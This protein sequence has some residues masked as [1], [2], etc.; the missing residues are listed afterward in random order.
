[1][2]RKF[3]AAILNGG[4]P[5]CKRSRHVLGLRAGSWS[6]KEPL[7]KLDWLMIDAVR[8]AVWDALR[9]GYRTQDDDSVEIEAC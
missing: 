8:N 5:P 4:G 1:M 2:R 7:P 6:W 3:M 9:Y